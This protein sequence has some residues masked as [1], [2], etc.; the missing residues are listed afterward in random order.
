MLLRQPG[1]VPVPLFCHVFLPLL[2]PLQCL[3]VDWIFELQVL[4]LSDAQFLQGLLFHFFLT[5]LELP[6]LILFE[7]NQPS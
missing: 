1:P 4:S 2:V 3:H 6:L 5:P 7:G